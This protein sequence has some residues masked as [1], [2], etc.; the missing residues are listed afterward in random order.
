MKRVR[1]DELNSLSDSC[2]REGKMGFFSQNADKTVGVLS[3]LT[4]G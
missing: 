1:S 4:G 2:G 3:F